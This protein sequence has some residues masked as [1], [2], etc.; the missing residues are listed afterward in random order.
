MRQP[1]VFLARISM[2]DDKLWGRVTVHRP[3]RFVLHQREELTRGLRT[4]I[5]IEGRGIK[6]GDLLVKLALGQANFP[7]EFQ[8]PL[9]MLISK[10]MT[11]FKH[12]T[13]MVQPWMV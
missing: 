4:P 8:L 12:S 13:S 10:H 2:S 5:V 1:L 11:F 6:I 9:E 3:V 7:N